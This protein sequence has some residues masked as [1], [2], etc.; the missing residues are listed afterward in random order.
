MRSQGDAKKR[1]TPSRVQR[2]C[3]NILTVYQQYINNL[4]KYNEILRTNTIK[5]SSNDSYQC[6]PASKSVAGSGGGGG[7]LGGGAAGACCSTFASKPNLRWVRIPIH[8]FYGLSVVVYDELHRSCLK[9]SRLPGC[10]T[11]NFPK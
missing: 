8:L 10:S 1:S 5:F 4:E 2:R 3:N 6:T 7:G 11:Q 9:V